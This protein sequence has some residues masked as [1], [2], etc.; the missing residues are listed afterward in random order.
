MHEQAVDINYGFPRL[1]KQGLICLK[2][3]RNICVLLHMSVKPR[4]VQ[5]EWE[6]HKAARAAPSQP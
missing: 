5:A 2:E 4:R 6:H 3:A 1:S